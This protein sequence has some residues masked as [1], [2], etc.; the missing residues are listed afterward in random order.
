M[1]TRLFRKAFREYKKQFDQIHKVLPSKSLKEL[2][3]YYYT[4]K[5]MKPAEYRG[6]QRH[7]SDDEVGRGSVRWNLLTLLLHHIILRIGPLYMYVH[8]TNPPS[9]LKNQ[10]FILSEISI[11]AKDIH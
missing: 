6:R 1:E 3:E 10:I 9:L 5:K 8:S 2:H 11:S 7:H 4:W